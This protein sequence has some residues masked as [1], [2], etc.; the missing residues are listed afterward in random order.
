M[1]EEVARSFANHRRVCHSTGWR[2][3]D[4]ESSRLWSA[5]VW[6]REG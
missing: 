2:V 4:A 3:L 1:K 5:V 6:G